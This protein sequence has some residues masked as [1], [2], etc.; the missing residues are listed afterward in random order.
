VTSYGV[1]FEGKAQRH[2]T[3]NDYTSVGSRPETQTD[4]RKNEDLPLSPD[5]LETIDNLV[6]EHRRQFLEGQRA[7]DELLRELAIGPEEVREHEEVM[8]RI[9][10]KLGI[11]SEAEELAQLFH[12]R[13]RRISEAANKLTDFQDSPP[14]SRRDDKDG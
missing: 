5:V 14:T 1:F 7:Q 12:D 2:M 6:A 8:R 9:F 11:S 3:D 13:Q 4:W 10:R